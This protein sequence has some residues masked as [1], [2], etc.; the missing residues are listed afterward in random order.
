LIEDIMKLEV[1]SMKNK[2][3]IT[4]FIITLFLSGCKSKGQDNRVPLAEYYSTPYPESTAEY[5]YDEIY[6]GSQEMPVSKSVSVL[7][8]SDG[9]ERKIVKNASI[10]IEVIDPIQAL[11]QINSMAVQYGGYVVNST[12]GQRYYQ[13]E[14]LL[15]YGE[16]TIRVSAEY[17][18]EALQ[19]IESMTTDVEK[20]V[21]SKTITGKD[22]TSDY[23][24]SQSRLSSLEATRKKLYEIMDTAETAEETLAVFHEISDIESQIEIL[25]GQIKF[26][27]ESAALSSIYV[28]INPIPPEKII[29]THD[30]AIKPILNNAV[31]LLIDFGQ[32][33]AEILTY[34]VIAVLPFIVVIGLP[35]FFIVR[36]VRKKN[37]RKE[38]INTE[39]SDL[40]KHE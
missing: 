20:H 12:N 22:I 16:T 27:D 21:S 36:A 37:K 23:V 40:L 29:E 2:I 9:V 38:K 32:L 25:K 8:Q 34:F 30:W 18:E 3:L 4:V 1:F 10:T 17:L 24:D 39:V 13:S 26:M 11:N 28:I 33:L 6:S 35:I 7:P 5:A 15:P 19:A 14:A 31:Q